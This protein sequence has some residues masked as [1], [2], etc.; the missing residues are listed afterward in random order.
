MPV[1]VKWARERISFELPSPDTPLSAI[2]ASLAD[3][4]HIPQHAFKLV[5]AGAVMKDDAAPISAYHLHPN[6]VIA[7]IGSA[8]A[9]PVATALPPLRAEQ[10][11]L[12]SIQA[13]LAQVRATLA[14][15]LALFLADP[16]HHKEHLR[17]GELLLQALIRLDSIAPEP[18]WEHA[19]R[20]R[21]DAVRE[22]QDML[23]RLDDA[24]AARTV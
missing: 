1:T 23:D 10:P 21:K 7:L 8:D 5:H 18:A 22:V 9:P 14:P 24:W 20:E 12:N 15:A 6:S 11:V 3:Y 19:R 13:E 2:R 4:T 17:L 16:T